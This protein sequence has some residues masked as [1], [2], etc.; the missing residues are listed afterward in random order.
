MEIRIWTWISGIVSY[1]L[2]GSTR[3]ISTSISGLLIMEIIIISDLVLLNSIIARLDSLLGRSKVLEAKVLLN[4][5]TNRIKLMIGLDIL[6]MSIG[7]I[8]CQS[9]IVFMIPR[10][11]F[12]SCRDRWSLK[13]RFRSS[14]K[15]GSSRL[16]I[17]L[18][19]MVVRFS[20]MI[21]IVWT[22]LRMISMFIVRRILEEDIG[23]IR[24]MLN[25]NL[26]IYLYIGCIC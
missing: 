23:I 19:R 21:M 12:I 24:S 1:Y 22:T 11:F 13:T 4:N 14:R 10:P 2:K 8:Y 20:S 15:V 6:I 18:G 16:S 3:T 25:D 5:F 17:S 9:K 7:N 26:D